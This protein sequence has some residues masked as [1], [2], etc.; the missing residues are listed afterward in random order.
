MTQASR[1]R[2]LINRPNT[3]LELI[4]SRPQSLMELTQDELKEFAIRLEADKYA[5]QRFHGAQ[6]IRVWEVLALHYYLDPGVLGLSRR[7][8]LTE[9]KKVARKL[10][11]LSV[12]L[13]NFIVSVPTVLQD[14]HAG[15]LICS[16]S[17]IDLLQRSTTLK[18]FKSY[19]VNRPL[20]AFPPPSL[21][22]RE[23]AS[24]HV[25][26]PPDL[27]DIWEAKELWKT[28]SEGGTVIPGRR[29]TEPNLVQFFRDRNYSYHKSKT[30]ASFLR[31]DFAPIGRPRNES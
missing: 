16:T 11:P 25:D 19:V 28:C 23:K 22:K 27:R 1:L 6:D 8:R 29:S 17:Q 4:S 10:A 13:L 21:A 12:R 9:L 24:V 7:G 31:P 5:R 15:K 18:D 2:D 30:L 26:M 14:I 20:H 3:G